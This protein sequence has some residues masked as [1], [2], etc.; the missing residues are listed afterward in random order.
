MK[1][2]ASFWNFFRKNEESIK[3]AL[4]LGIKTEE[5]FAQFDKK[6]NTVSR[7]IGY[8]IMEP[9]ETRDKYTIVFT[10]YGY[11]KLFAKVQGLADLQPPLE[12]FAIVAF[13]KPMTETALFYDGTDKPYVFP[14]ASIKVSECFFTLANFNIATKQLQINVYIPNYNDF[15]DDPET[16]ENLSF[17]LSTI[18]GEIAFHKHLKAV[19]FKQTPTTTSSLEPLITLQDYINYLYTINS[20]RKTRAI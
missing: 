18:I 17:L 1:Q 8:I 11:R 6:L 4:Q 12:Y 7:R 16:D 13:I 20:R 3:N 10:A 15:K 9:T 14:Q 5:V 2:I 19:T